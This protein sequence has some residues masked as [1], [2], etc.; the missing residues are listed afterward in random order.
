M[1]REAVK[2][3]TA[4]GRQAE[5]LMKSGGLV[6]DDLIIGVIKDA[7]SNIEDKS[8]SVVFDGFPRTLVQA[9]KLDEMLNE[10]NKTIKKVVCFEVD[11]SV[12]IKRICG[13]LTH[14]ASGRT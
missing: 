11:D 1:L 5:A 2:N 12:V 3:Q 7:L 8:R 14:T 10:Q 4:V 6:G 9:K 13:R